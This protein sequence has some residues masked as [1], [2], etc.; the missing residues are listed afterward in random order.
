[1]HLA[2]PATS[3]VEIRE[4]TVNENILSMDIADAND[5]EVDR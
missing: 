2:E 5:E 4:T 3:T 1:M